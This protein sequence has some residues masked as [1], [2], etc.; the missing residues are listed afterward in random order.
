MGLWSGLKVLISM[1]MPYAAI[2]SSKFSLRN[3]WLSISST[4]LRVKI[5]FIQ[6]SDSS[7]DSRLCS[8]NSS[9]SSSDSG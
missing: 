5:S 2:N 9:D 4:N 3:C 1:V 7:S 6:H 8:E